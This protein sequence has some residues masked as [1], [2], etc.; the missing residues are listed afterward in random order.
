MAIFGALLLVLIYALAGNGP[1][2]GTPR[3]GGEYPLTVRRSDNLSDGTA[4]LVGTNDVYLLG[5]TITNH[6]PTTTFALTKFMIAP[7]RGNQYPVDGVKY[8]RIYDG[9]TQIFEVPVSD[10][11]AGY[12]FASSTPTLILPPS[13]S[14][15]FRVVANVLKPIPEPADLRVALGWITVRRTDDQWLDTG[16]FNED[17][18]MPLRPPD[19]DPDYSVESAVFSAR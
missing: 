11:Q 17:A 15:N 19:Q 5:F 4:V 18:N 10:P 12:A 16:V 1:G 9:N 7:G 2:T 8:I 14:K 6:T 3:G 13:S